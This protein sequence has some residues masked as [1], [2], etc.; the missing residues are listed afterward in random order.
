[1]PKR[2]KKI[3]EEVLHENP[4]WKYKHDI[5][6]LPNGQEGNYYYG[7]TSGVAIIVPVLPDGRIVLTLQHRYL[8]DKQSIEFPAG[9]ILPGVSALD[10]AKKELQEETG[11]IA[12]EFIKIG[13]FE[14]SNG[15]IKDT[16]HVFLAH[17]AEQG[18]QHPDETEEIEVLYR[19]PDDIEQM[20]RKNEIWDGQTMATWAMIRHHFIKE[21]S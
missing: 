12:S 17:I 20:I 10:G 7:E 21:Q 3:S 16:T 13:V 1:M 15:F 6:E 11:C 4:W 2:L 5:Y 8:K 19:R 18:D 14:P 9:G